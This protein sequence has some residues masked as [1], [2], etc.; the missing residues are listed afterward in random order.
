MESAP[1]SASYPPGAPSPVT[2]WRASMD[3]FQ[4]FLSSFTNLHA[5][6]ILFQIYLMGDF[7]VSL[8]LVSTEMKVVNH[9]DVS[10]YKVSSLPATTIPPAPP[11]QC[12]L[13]HHTAC[14]ETPNLPPRQSTSYQLYSNTRYLESTSTI[15]LIARYATPS[16]I[17][18]VK[19]EQ[20]HPSSSLAKEVSVIAIGHHPS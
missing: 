11:P 16:Q 10:K 1:L 8:D 2:K 6:G 9:V 20:H 7:V 13:R 19:P 5:D 17:A 3:L 14:P 12:P 4:E 15:P 18:L